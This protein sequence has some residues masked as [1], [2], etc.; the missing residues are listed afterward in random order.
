ML[1]HW[2]E[3][4]FLLI[5]DVEHFIRCMLSI[6]GHLRTLFGEMSIQV[7]CPFLK[8]VICFLFLMLMILCDSLKVLKL[9]I[10]LMDI[11]FRQFPVSSQKGGNFSNY[12]LFY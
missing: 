11:V 9:K 6:C 1:A 7:P 8:S 2:F 4:R 3:L 10:N 5:S 12:K